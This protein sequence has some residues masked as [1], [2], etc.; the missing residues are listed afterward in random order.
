MVVV[1]NDDAGRRWGNEV[2]ASLTS[3]G[4]AASVLELPGLADR[5][6]VSEWL[7]A[8]HTVDELKALANAAQLW[9]PP[10]EPVVT[11][12]DRASSS[13]PA[14]PEPIDPAAY[15]GLAGDVVRAID[16]HTEADPAALL[17]SF[18]AA[19]G[20]AVG[21]A[22]HAVVG[23]THHY[24]RLNVVLVGETARARKGD[25]WAADRLLMVSADPQWGAAC[26]Q[27]GLSSG[28]GLI[29][30]VRDPI[31]QTDR[32]TGET[33][34]VD[35]GVA[36][37]RLLV[38]EAEFARTL[39]VMRRDG[40]TLSS[41]IRDAWDTGTLR[42]MT[43]TQLRAT[44]S[45]ISVIG[46]ITVDEIRRELDETSLANGFAN[47]FL[48][49]AVRRSKVLAEPEPF[50]GAKVD[51]L[52]GRISRAIAF[53]RG[54]GVVERDQEAREAWR[55]VYPD[56]T[57]DRPGMLGAILNRSE[58]HAVRLSLIYAILDRSATVRH[59]HLESALAVLDYVDA[60]VRFIFANRLGDPVADAILR[61]V[62]E[63]GEKSRNELRDLFSR[64]VSA[65]RIGAALATLAAA[66][67]LIRE[68]RPTEGRPAETWKLPE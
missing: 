61:A 32:K 46:H 33:T 18:L 23:S 59:V 2:A 63:T 3:V 54:T 9:T 45:H 37:K 10:V 36:D 19:F 38:I 6:D 35:A 31:S 41:I 50:A 58:A 26:I 44:G 62:T 29:S 4:C 49:G 5:G 48:W 42:V 57:A 64:H 39:R 12:P 66:G 21:P 13:S 15:R 17:M 14:W 22:A 47:R 28:E 68:S 60:S 55:V 1:D 52:A 16:P 34:I 67:L 24:G 40:S 51:E 30:A 53:G 8:G 56:L 27:G 11:V 65:E 43:K 20:N 25:S 7:D